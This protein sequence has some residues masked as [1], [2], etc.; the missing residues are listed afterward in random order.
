M[1]LIGLAFVSGDEPLASSN[2][3]RTGRV[4]MRHVAKTLPLRGEAYI[5][6]YIDIHHS[7]SHPSSWTISQFALEKLPG[8]KNER[9]YSS[10]N[11]F[12]RGE[13]FNFTGVDD[14]WGVKK[15]THHVHPRKIQWLD[16]LRA[17]FFFQKEFI[18]T[19]CVLLMTCKGI[20]KGIVVYKHVWDPYFWLTDMSFDPHGPFLKIYSRGT[21]D[22]SQI[23]FLPNSFAVYRGVY[24]PAI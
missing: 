21:S 8:P 12:F 11:P 6:F 18:W 4:D 10:K 7:W 5:E 9:V 3:F 19:P 23:S 13:L 16:K 14:M 1:S 17:D 24:Y 22:L 15:W 2:R 20:M